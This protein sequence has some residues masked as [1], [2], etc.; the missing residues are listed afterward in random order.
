MVID[1]VESGPHQAQVEAPTLTRSLISGTL[2]TDTS[3]CTG[4][5]LCQK[6]EMPKWET[7][8]MEFPYSELLGHS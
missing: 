5:H 1:T 2:S 3:S 4:E 6:L 8:S 7:R